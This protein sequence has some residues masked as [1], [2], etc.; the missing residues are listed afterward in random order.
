MYE[1]GRILPV[2]LSVSCRSRQP[3]PSSASPSRVCIAKV[4]GRVRHKRLITDVCW[5]GTARR[6]YERSRSVQPLDVVSDCSVRIHRKVEVIVRALS[7][8]AAPDSVT[9]YAARKGCATDCRTLARNPSTRP[10][11]RTRGPK[12]LLGCR[13]TAQPAPRH[14]LRC[15][16]VPQGYRHREQCYQ[17]A[18]MSC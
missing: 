11:W 1:F 9:E 7:G 5:Q 2:D 17:R 14:S 15:N 16:S 6:R 10:R 4:V 18:K 12:H 13:R 8:T 3:L